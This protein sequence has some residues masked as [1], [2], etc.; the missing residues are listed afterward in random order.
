MKEQL[1]QF[2]KNR[3][4][5]ITVEEINQIMVILEKLENPSM[6]KPVKKKK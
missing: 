6:E 1:I 4:T 5:A 3:A 2:F